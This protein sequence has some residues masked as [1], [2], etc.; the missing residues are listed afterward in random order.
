M[1]TARLNPTAST[2]KKPSAARKVDANTPLH[3]VPAGARETGITTHDWLA[4]MA[5][6]GFIMRGLKIQA[7]RAMTEDEKDDEMAQ[8]S[9]KMAAAMLRAQPEAAKQKQ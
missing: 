5:M 4:A 1:T 9:Y 3:S 2:A 6:Q 7:D 8:R